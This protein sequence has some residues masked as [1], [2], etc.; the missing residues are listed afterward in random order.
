MVSIVRGLL[1]AG[2]ATVMVTGVARADASDVPVTEYK[3]HFYDV[4][5]NETYRKCVAWRESRNNP[6]SIGGQHRGMYQFTP[7]L[8][9]GVAWM[10][11]A[12]PGE[13]IT[14]KQRL[15][16]Q[17]RPMT[18]WSRY[19]QDRAFYTVYNWHGPASGAKH[20]HIAGSTCNGLT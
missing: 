4:Y 8:A 2:L 14:R 5:P 1:V 6:R 9:H 18:K 10:M 16:L 12:A 11:R 3:G 20:W 17:S 7:A 15:W 19:W 13:R